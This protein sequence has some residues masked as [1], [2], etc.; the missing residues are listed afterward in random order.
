[1]LISVHMLQESE[2]CVSLESLWSGLFVVEDSNMS[3]FWTEKVIFIVRNKKKK[4]MLIDSFC[5][6]GNHFYLTLSSS[7]ELPII[8]TLIWYIILLAFIQIHL[9]GKPIYQD[10]HKI[11]DHWNEFC[12]LK[13]SEV[14]KPI[15]WCKWHS[16]LTSMW[17]EKLSC[18]VETRTFVAQSHFRM[19]F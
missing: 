2:Y 15:C 6:C 5:C 16:Q 1:M 18:P 8:L 3:R 4:H 11:K 17:V 10:V 13:D 7:V 14:Q 9:Y 12:A 19:T